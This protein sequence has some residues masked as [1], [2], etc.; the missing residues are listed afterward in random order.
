MK[1]TFQL[2]VANKNKDRQVESIKNDVRKYIKRERTK[3]LPENCNYWNFDCKFGKTQE[4]ATEIRFVD[5]TKSIDIAASKNLES[6]YLELVARA[7]FR[8]PKEKNQE[9]NE[10]DE[11]LED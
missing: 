4:E 8:K 9:N 3:R 6:F 2:I 11:E 1:K 10:E 5:I 7:E